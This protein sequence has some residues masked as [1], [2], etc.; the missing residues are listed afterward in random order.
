[1][2]PSACS[3]VLSAVETWAMLLLVLDIHILSVNH[4]FVF[5]STSTIA[6]RSRALP[7]GRPRTRSR[8]RSLIHLLRQLVRCRRQLLASRVHRG[9][10]S[11]LDGLLRVCQSV[12]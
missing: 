11:A 5:F 1:M 12:L 4:A 7:V 8:L 10:V 9:L 3:S 6:A 2:P